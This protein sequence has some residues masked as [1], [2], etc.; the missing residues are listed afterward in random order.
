ML[1]VFINLISKFSSDFRT[2]GG[3]SED[4]DIHLRLYF[5]TEPQYANPKP[6]SNNIQDIADTEFLRTVDIHKKNQIQSLIEEASNKVGPVVRIFDT[7][8]PEQKCL[9][10]VFQTGTTHSFFSGVTDVYHSLGM[11]SSTKYVEQFANGMTLFYLNLTTV[12]PNV[13]MDV[14]F[15]RELINQT[16]LTYMLA[17]TSLTPLLVNGVLSIWEHAYGT[18]SLFSQN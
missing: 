16:T 12:L 13:T 5:L 2:A 9:L 15:I 11:K 18:F 3:V 6:T 8:L 14:D 4:S 10:V 17:R 7:E 1:Q